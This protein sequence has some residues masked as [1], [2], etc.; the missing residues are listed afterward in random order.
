MT[1]LVHCAIHEGFTLLRRIGSPPRCLGDLLHLFR[2]LGD[3]RKNGID[4][5]FRLIDALHLLI[6]ADRNLTYIAGYMV[7]SICG[8]LR[9]G[10][11]FLRRSRNLLGRRRH[12][13]DELAD[14]VAHR[15][16]RIAQR[17]DLILR[18]HLDIVETKIAAGK[19]VRVLLNLQH[20]SCDAV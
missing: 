7:R 14:I 8:L 13:A 10:R 1:H 12:L 9:A 16:E 6:H 3:I 17:T 18:I 20:R 4:G 19:L 11:E 15:I 2:D 5:L